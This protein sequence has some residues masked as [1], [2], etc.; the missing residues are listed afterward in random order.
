MASLL[1]RSAEGWVGWRRGLRKDGRSQGGVTLGLDI[2]GSPSSRTFLVNLL[3]L[4]LLLS[5]DAW[6]SLLLLGVLEMVEQCRSQSWMSLL[7]C[8]GWGAGHGVDLLSRIIVSSAKSTV[9]ASVAVDSLPI[10]VLVKLCILQV[11]E[12]SRSQGRVTFL[13]SRD[14]VVVLGRGRG[15]NLAH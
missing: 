13:S 8:R 11:V 12:Q 6:S 4:L 15:R 9:A 1:V 10:A 7:A 5:S 14:V 2:I 3:L